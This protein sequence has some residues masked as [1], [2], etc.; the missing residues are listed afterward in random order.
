[1]STDLECGN[2]KNIRKISDT[3][4]ILETDGD[5]APGYNYYFCLKLIGESK[6]ESVEVD[7]YA[8]Q[9]LGKKDFG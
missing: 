7:I 8:D 3:Y 1:V 9:S 4:F 2:G 5:Q 6:K